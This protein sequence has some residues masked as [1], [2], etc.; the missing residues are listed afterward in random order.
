VKDLTNFSVEAWEPSHDTE[1]WKNRHQ[2][3]I[4]VQCAYQGDG[5]QSVAVNARPVFVL[6]VE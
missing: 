5:E 4:Y 1:L 3:D 6:T 2:L